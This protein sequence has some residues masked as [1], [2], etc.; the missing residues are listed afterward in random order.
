MSLA[1]LTFAVACADPLADVER[2][3]DVELAADAPEATIMAT[4]TEPVDVVGLLGQIFGGGTTAG[5]ASEPEEEQSVALPV[6]PE[7]GAAGEDTAEPGLFDFLGLESSPEAAAALQI[8]PGTVLPF[9]E[10]ATVCGLR[11]RNLGAAINTVA[12]YT[13]YD[14][15]PGAATPRTHYV[16]GFEDGCARQFTAALVVFGDVGTH[17][18]LR[19]APTHSGVPYSE[20]D[21]AY[22]ALKAQFCRVAERQPCGRRLEALGRNTVFMTVYPRFGG[23]GDWFEVLLHG[24]E[25]VATGFEGAG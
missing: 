3:S 24:G 6:V 19:Y 22:E 2:L 10:L 25:V 9:G 17:E 23:N 16:T 21:R 13:T 11:A 1:A 12:G 4:E 5:P 20:T 18:F 8:Q 15:Q 14:S 7:I